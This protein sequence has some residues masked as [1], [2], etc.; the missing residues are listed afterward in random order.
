MRP[1]LMTSIAAIGMMTASCA[2]AGPTTNM[3]KSEIETL[4]KEYILENPEIIR[5]AIIKL[6]EKE[7]LKEQELNKESIVSAKDALENDPRDASVGPEDAKV[8][9]VEFFDYNCGY[10]KR[11]TPWVEEAVEK[12]GNDVR[13][14]FKELPILDDRT[15]TSRIAAR[16]ALAADK[17]GKYKEMHFAL[18]DQKRLSGDIVRETAEKIGLDMNRYEADMAD[19]TI[20]QH[21]N[22]TL[23]LANRLPA[24]T[25]TPFFIVGDEYVSGADTDR[26]EMLVDAA[27]KG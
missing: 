18:M 15:K 9:I 19:P 23:Q 7:V 13:I 8:T 1:F 25:G 5:D 21:I 20:D 27:L 12:Y 17:Q 24:L 26:L 6:Q 4:V 22:D 2:E 11:A 10:C 14:V 16:A 3:S